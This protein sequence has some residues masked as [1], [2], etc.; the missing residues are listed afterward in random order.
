MEAIC[1]GNDEFRYYLSAL[2]C[3]VGVE[4]V[5]FRSTRCAF[6]AVAEAWFLLSMSFVG[7]LLYQTTKYFGIEK[8]ATWIWLIYL[9]ISLV[10]ISHNPTLARHR[11]DDKK[12]SNYDLQTHICLSSSNI[13]ASFIH[14]FIIP[15]SS[16]ISTWFRNAPLP[17]TFANSRM[18]TV[19][20]SNDILRYRVVWWP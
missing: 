2:L 13:E 3:N 7:V 6:I 8:H 12:L 15:N 18:A 19:F 20:I 9:C 10:H 16:Y 14:L 1:P 11:I 17:F 4:R 5:S